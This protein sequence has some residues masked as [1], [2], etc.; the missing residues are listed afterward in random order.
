MIFIVTALGG[1]THKLVRFV[2][3]LRSI[4]GPDRLKFVTE[5]T[6][7]ELRFVL[8]NFKEANAV[9]VLAAHKD[10]DHKELEK[11]A[12]LYEEKFGIPVFMGEVWD[13][14]P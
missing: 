9:T 11:Y 5:T 7:Y 6:D 1:E 10:L 4:L 8:E 12:K 2:E 14:W 3:R 13:L